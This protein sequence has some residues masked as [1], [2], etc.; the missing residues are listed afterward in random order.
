MSK[1][2]TSSMF[3]LLSVRN[4]VSFG[5]YIFFFLSLPSTSFTPK[6]QIK[7]FGKLP[8]IFHKNHRKRIL[9]LFFPSPSL[10]RSRYHK[11]IFLIVVPL[12]HFHIIAQDRVISQNKHGIENEAELPAFFLFSL[13]LCL[14]LIPLLTILSPTLNALFVYGKK[15]CVRQAPISVS[16]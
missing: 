10:S 11:I 15:L 9:K 3:L 5:L 12:S 14:V 13:F 1:T 2:S 8:D 4:V 7:T 6:R 16:P